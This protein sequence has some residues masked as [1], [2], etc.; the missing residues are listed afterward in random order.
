MA[1]VKEKEALFVCV[2]TL[3]QKVS[4]NSGK[5]YFFVKLITFVLADEKESP[6]LFPI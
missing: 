3:S 6:C 4:Y 5:C 2:I 1:M